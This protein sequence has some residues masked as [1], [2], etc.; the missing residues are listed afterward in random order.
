MVGTLKAADRTAH[1][2]ATVCTAGPTG[3]AGCGQPVGIAATPHTS[4]E[5]ALS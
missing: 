4:P 5:T 2:P 3:C 1:A